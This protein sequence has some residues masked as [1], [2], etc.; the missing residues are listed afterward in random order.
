MSTARSSL[1]LPARTGLAAGI[2]LAVLAVAVAAGRHR[3][4]WRGARSSSRSRC[5]PGSLGLFLL[6]TNVP[7]GYAFVAGMVASVNPCGGVLLPADLGLYLGDDK[8]AVG[9]GVWQAAPSWSAPP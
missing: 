1:R 2:T 3:P 4:R 9:A 8:S 5:Q 6:G 7:L